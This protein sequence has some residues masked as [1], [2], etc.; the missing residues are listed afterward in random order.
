MRLVFLLILLLPVVLVVIALSPRG[1]QR[2][3]LRIRDRQG[4]VLV[5]YNDT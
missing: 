1:G 4:R 5:D 3:A 2:E